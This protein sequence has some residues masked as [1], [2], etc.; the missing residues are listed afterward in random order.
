MVASGGVYSLGGTKQVQVI[1]NTFTGSDGFGV[2]VDYVAGGQPNAWDISHNRF[3]A[4]DSGDLRMDNLLTSVVTNNFFNSSSDSTT[5]QDN[6]STVTVT[7][8]LYTLAPSV[9][10]SASRYSNNQGPVGVNTNF[11]TYTPTLTDA[12]NVSASTAYDCQWSRTGGVVTASGRVDVTITSAAVLT[13][14]LM[15]IPV[16]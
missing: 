8:N 9:K 7:N 4:N 6:N 11:G 16:A 10:S 13:T 14:S 2:N 5:E 12:T 3:F 15:S 1:S